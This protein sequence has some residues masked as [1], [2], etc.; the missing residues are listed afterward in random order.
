LEPGYP[1]PFA[2][3]CDEGSPVSRL[4]DRV[5]L[6]DV[7]YIVLLDLPGDLGSEPGEEGIDGLV[8]RPAAVRP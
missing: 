2:Q 3:Q 4:G 5:E 7:L 8:R 6:F 1:H